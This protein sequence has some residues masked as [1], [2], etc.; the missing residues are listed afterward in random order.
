LDV[1]GVNEPAEA[2]RDER[3]SGIMTSE[4]EKRRSCQ[5]VVVRVVLALI[6]LGLVL[7]RERS[8]RATEAPSEVRVVSSADFGRSAPLAPGSL[9]TAFGSRLA[10]QTV[11]ADT[12]APPASLGGTSVRVRGVLA[13]VTYV[14]PGQ[15]NFQI[16]PGLPV[17]EAS[18]TITAGDG[19]VSQAVTRLTPVSPALFAA[20]FRNKV[21]VGTALRFRNGVQVASQSL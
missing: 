2:P 5:W 6:M 14:S 18:I 15:V 12:E 10:T 9:A 20:D 7:N 3:R 11:T 16:P 13:L 8:G 1:G 21:P 17:G 4:T 19:T